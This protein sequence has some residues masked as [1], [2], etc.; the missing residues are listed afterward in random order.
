MDHNV[1]HVH[2]KFQEADSIVQWMDDVVLIKIPD[3]VNGYKPVLGMKEIKA[4]EY[5]K[6]LEDGN[7]KKKAKK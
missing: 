5:H 3:W 7:K 2:A 6:L 1:V 4:S